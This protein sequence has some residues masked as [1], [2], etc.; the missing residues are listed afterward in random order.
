MRRM[1]EV[2]KKEDATRKVQK[3]K[4]MEAVVIKEARRM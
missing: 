2:K 1:E 4:K 3:A